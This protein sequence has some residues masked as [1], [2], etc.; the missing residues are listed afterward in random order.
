MNNKVDVKVK[1]R[2]SA[3]RRIMLSEEMLSCLQNES[4]NILSKVGD[5]YTSDIYKGK[6]R[7]N[8]GIKANTFIA[9]TD[10]LKHNTLLKSLN[11]KR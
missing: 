1:I 7:L 9:K 10:N 5:G 6:N 3:I 8:V 4:D 11:F 2:R